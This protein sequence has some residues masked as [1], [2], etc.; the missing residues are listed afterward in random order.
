MHIQEP[1]ARP[2]RFN[3]NLSPAV[4]KVI[5]KAMA[6]DPEERYP[7]VAGMNQ[8]YQAAVRGSA[9]TE[10][11]WLQLRGP[12]EVAV[13]RQV[14]L[15]QE[16]QER[17]RRR[18]P[19]VWLLAGAALALLVGGVVGAAALSS[20]GDADEPSVEPTQTAPTAVSQIAAQPS[21]PPKATAT[22]AV[23]EECPLVSLLGYEN[24]GSR[25][26][27]VI[28]NGQEEEPLHV[29]DF[30]FGVPEGHSLIDVRLGSTSLRDP[31]SASTGSPLPDLVTLEDEATRVAPGATL[32]LV[33]EFAFA[34][35]SPGYQII[36]IFKE[37]CSVETS[38]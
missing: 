8:A 2:S 38:W 13:A 4:E 20:L 35:E 21:A 3:P 26:S 5:L 19:L 15:T 32:P 12:N 27:W 14:A 30:L 17:R 10:A 6:K 24:D 36:V 29:S 9:Q 31:D 23:S 25:V 11:D 34:D 16:Q 37:G 33:L 18:S 22:P 1:V 7:T 28:Y